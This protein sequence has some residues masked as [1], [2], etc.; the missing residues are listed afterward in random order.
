MFVG[1]LWCVI[2]HTLYVNTTLSQSIHSRMIQT[3]WDE[4]KKQ[5]PVYLTIVVI[6]IYLFS[7]MEKYRTVNDAIM[8]ELRACEIECAE[9]RTRIEQAERVFNNSYEAPPVLPEVKKKRKRK[10][11]E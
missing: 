7:E 4:A 11:T 2:C 6:C 10:T 9:L 8:L 1:C 5:G 3:I